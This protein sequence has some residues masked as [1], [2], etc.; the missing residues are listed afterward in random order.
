MLSTSATAAEIATED[1][2]T[3]LTGV[4]ENFLSGFFQGKAKKSN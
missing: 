2:P 1:T 4:E 3:Y